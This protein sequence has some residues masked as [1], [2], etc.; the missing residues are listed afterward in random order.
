MKY[1]KEQIST[2]M[3]NLDGMYKISITD[4]MVGK[5]E[6]NR[7]N[8]AIDIAIDCMEQVVAI[9]EALVDDGK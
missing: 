1:S 9:R 7:I 6:A 8:N 4:N 2:A 5:A 3:N